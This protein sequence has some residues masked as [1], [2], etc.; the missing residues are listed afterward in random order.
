MRRTLSLLLP[1]IALMGLIYFL[2]AQPNLNSGL[3]IWDKIL[4]KGAHMLEFGLLAAL[5]YRALANGFAPW[6]P[7]LM[8]LGAFIAVA[9]AA[10]DEVHQQSVVGRH[11]SLVDVI[12]DSIGILVAA[13]LV[14]RAQRHKPAGPR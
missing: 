12:V 3:G 13:A 10:L 8:F 5:W 14:A 9:Y 1:P 4:R 6:K 11:S 7:Q 2:S